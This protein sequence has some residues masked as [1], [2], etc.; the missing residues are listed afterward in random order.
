MACE[1]DA[2]RTVVL[3][4]IQAACFVRGVHVDVD[5]DGVLAAVEPDVALARLTEDQWEALCTAVRPFLPSIVG[6]V[7]AGVGTD[8]LP[9]LPAEAVAVDGS[10][11]RLASETLWVPVG[12]QRALRAQHVIHAWAGYGDDDPFIWD[13]AR[14][15]ARDVTG[16]LNDLT[17][18]FDIP[19]RV[20]HQDRRT[21]NRWQYR[22][23]VTITELADA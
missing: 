9:E 16:A 13:T 10:A 6:L 3:R 2:E 8:V 18:H 19:L 17:R 14:H 15:V 1:S 21:Q 22:W 4:A 5:L 11:V 20:R 23:G 7:A 12:A